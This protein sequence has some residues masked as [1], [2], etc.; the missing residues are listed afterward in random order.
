MADLPVAPAGFEEHA[1]VLSDW[2]VRAGGRGEYAVA[3]LNEDFLRGAASYTGDA[4]LPVRATNA[5][6]RFAYYRRLAYHLGY[7]E[8]QSFPDEVRDA[9]GGRWPRE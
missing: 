6:L 7:T 5:Q 3:L 4:G 1:A 8:R 9:V 2:V